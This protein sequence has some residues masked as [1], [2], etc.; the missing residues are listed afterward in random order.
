MAANKPYQR[1]Y[2]RYPLQYPLIF[3]GRAG[4]GEGHLSNISFN[5]CSVMCDRALD[6]GTTV[7]LGVI[8]P[9]HTHALSID[10]GTIIWADD[11]EFGVEFQFLSLR[12]RQLLNQI[13]RK[14]L[15]YGLQTHSSPLDRSPILS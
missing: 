11:S 10:G 12:A 6:V 4:V 1:M 5:G 8:L 14:A 15:I 7:R 13:L 2:L 3:G 9:D